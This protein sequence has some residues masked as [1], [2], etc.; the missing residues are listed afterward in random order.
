MQQDFEVCCGEVGVCPVRPFDKADAVAFEILVEASLKKLF[1]MG[2]ARKI[3]VLYT[4]SRICIRFD[5][6]VRRALHPAGVAQP[7]QQAAGQRGFAGTQVAAQ[8]H[9]QPRRER[10][11]QAGTGSQR[12]VPVGQVQVG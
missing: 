9:R 1:C 10:R 2:E 4:N 12:G 5:Q 8:E 7:T 3:K 11:R 6:G